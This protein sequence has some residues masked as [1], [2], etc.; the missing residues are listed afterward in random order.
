MDDFSTT[1]GV[2]V[3]SSSPFDYHQSSK[4]I[5][6]EERDLIVHLASNNCYS[7][8]AEDVWMIWVENLLDSTIVKVEIQYDGIDQSEE[9]NTIGLGLD[10]FVQFITGFSLEISKTG[11]SYGTFSSTIRVIDYQDNNSYFTFDQMDEVS[12][13]QIPLDNFTGEAD[14]GEVKAVVLET[15]VQNCVIVVTKFALT[16]SR[17]KTKEIVTTQIDFV[18]ESSN[19]TTFPFC[20]VLI[21]LLCSFHLL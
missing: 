16:Q 2:I 3:D 5:L 4:G 13:L 9:I 19:A 6:G 10:F 8:V 11:S 7:I 21:F 15:N 17:E 20:A 14:W 18:I 1:S 12:L